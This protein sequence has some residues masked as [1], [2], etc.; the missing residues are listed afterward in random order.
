[1]T[2][3]KVLEKMKVDELK[4]LAKNI[5]IQG[6]SKL[7]KSELIHSIQVKEQELSS[8]TEDSDKDT[9]KI[10]SIESTRSVKDMDKKTTEEQKTK[11]DALRVSGILELHT[12]G[13]GFMRSS[14][15]SSGENDVYVSPVQVKRFG[16]RTGDFIVGLAGEKTEKEKFSPL[17]Y[18][19]TVNHESLNHL[20]NRPIFEELTPIFPENQYVLETDPKILST[21]ILDLCCPIGKGQRGLIVAPPKVGKTTLLKLIANAISENY[22]DVYIIILLVDERPEEV[23]DMK[24]SVK[25][26]VI[27]STFDEP[28]Q[29]HIRIAEIVIERAKRLVEHKKDVVVLVDSI[30]RL[31]RAYNVALPNSGKILSGGLDPMALSHPKRFFGAARNLEEGGSLTILA[32][33]LIETGSRMDDVIYEEFKGTGNMEVH[34]DRNLSELGVFPAI[35]IIKSGTRREELLLDAPTLNVTQK[36]RQ[37]LNVEATDFNVW[38]KALKILGQ[39]E[40]NKVFIDTVRRLDFKSL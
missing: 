32:T 17:I 20:K 33:A 5:G 23:T 37:E 24:R 22:K 39:T 10:K 7:K 11:K 6:F 38:Q 8:D 25:G 14:G 28:P 36:I 35:D 4:N 26:E 30:T 21:R 12:D 40:N 15:Y 1:M 19:H 31:T 13:F 29:N 27:S 34:L 2:D 3:I 18:I 9:P 16:L